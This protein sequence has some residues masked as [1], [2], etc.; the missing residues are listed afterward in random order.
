MLSLRTINYAVPPEGHF[1]KWSADYEAIE[2][3]DGRT[4]AM[5]PEV[6][7][8]L[9][10]LDS[11][12]GIP[13]LGS[14]LLLLAA[15]RDEWPAQ[16]PL[17]HAVIR[18]ILE[19]SQ[20][21]SIPPEVAAVLITGLDLINNLPKDLR[22]SLAAKC[23]LITATFEGGP[24]SLPR[25]ESAQVMH[26]LSVAVIRLSNPGALPQM[27]S[28][29][30]FL[31]DIRALK[32]GLARHDAA[33]LESR[34]R[35]GLDDPRIQEPQLPEP[36]VKP[37]DPRDLFDRLIASGG[38]GGA[39]AA[40]AKRAI[41]MMNFPGRFGTP[42]DLPVGGI[43]D[44]TN[45]GTIDRLLPG[46]LA[47][48]DLVL[49]ARLVHN[50]AL[51]FR[52]EIP[53]MDVAVS[54]TVLLD[55][56][57]RLWG[58][59]RVFSLGVALGLP[60]HPALQ[61]PGETFEVAAATTDAFE[62]LDLTLPEGVRGALETLVPAAGPE[63]FLAAWWDAAKIVDDPSIP[64]LTF[65][66]AR[67]HLDDDA[68][69]RLLGEIAA[70]IHG[71]DGRFRVIALTRGGELEMQ[72]WSPGGNRLLCRG[73][74]DLDALLKPPAPAAGPSTPQPPP[75]RAK[76]DPLHQILP[77]YALDRL[78]FLFPLV[79]QATAY[80]EDPDGSGIGISVNRR[81]MHWPKPGWGGEELVAELPGRQHWI[82]RDEHGG[83]IVIAS[84]ETAGEAVRVFRWEENRLEEIEVE[85]SRHPF[86]R[87]AAVNGGVVILAYQDKVEALS[88]STGRRVAEQAVKT[89]PAVPVLHFD[90]LTIH[91][92]D[93][94]RKPS[95]GRDE[96][97]LTDTTWP[98]MFIPD[99]V[100]LEKAVLRV[101]I[102]DKCLA[103]D[104]INLVWSETKAGTHR[105]LP[106]EETSHSPAPGITLKRAIWSVNMAIW[107][108]S[109]GMLHLRDPFCADPPPWSIL[110]STQSTSCWSPAWMLCA[111]EPRLRQPA[112]EESKF[113][114]QVVLKDFLE[115][116]SSTHRPP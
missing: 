53:P 27:P 65:I 50:E 98:R 26:D 9:N 24:H 93:S 31:R 81:L 95:F 36:A 25:K 4:L 79:P 23:H 99:R 46:E 67:E 105:F 102:A 114:P 116:S 62:Y 76:P 38:E 82:G 115:C 94:G 20:S 11:D 64:D 8:V 73:E 57:L 21:D 12:S 101:T 72:A 15:C 69:R 87:H 3:A 10:H 32:V 40:V 88:L 108:D 104:P 14:V 39:A 41:A 60:H 89:L 56:G 78:P 45:R 44:I 47:W 96:W 54:H 18:P 97:S 30:R 6:L 75:L 19:I 74:L 107:L 13:P 86:P 68:T 112:T 49:A 17:N 48:D 85:A 110:L 42:R 90:G 34:L 5:W 109:R 33:S 113:L 51:Y 66:T 28:K 22:S 55:R 83:T 91:V 59:G 35:T 16:R 111:F 2:W 52:R 61:G 84:G 71:K 77:I 43:A 63:A 29:P 58:T 103:F 70:W 106:F 37:G 1:W 7:T 80:L 92:E 100:S